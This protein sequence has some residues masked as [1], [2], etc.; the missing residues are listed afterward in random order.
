MTNT[1]QAQSMV[2]SEYETLFAELDA[3][4]QAASP[5]LDHYLEKLR[6]DIAETP[7]MVWKLSPEQIG[8]IVRGLQVQSRIEIV[9]SSAAKKKK[10]DIGGLADAL[11]LSTTGSKS[12][13]TM[14]DLMSMPIG[15][16]AKGTKATAV[17]PDLSSIPSAAPA[18]NSEGRPLTM[19]ERLALRAKNK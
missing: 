14:A 5:N 17:L 12:K 13:A 18:V 8:K 4:L 15:A 7:E 2:A 10:S 6:K 9:S 19:A 11:G 1:S 3:E 16:V